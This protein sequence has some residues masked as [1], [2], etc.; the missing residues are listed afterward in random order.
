MSALTVLTVL[1]TQI[2]TVNMTTQSRKKDVCMYVFMYL[3]MYGGRN[4]FRKSMKQRADPS[5][6][7]KHRKRITYFIVRLKGR[8]NCE[9]LIKH[10]KSKDKE[11]TKYDRCSPH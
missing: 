10:L 3:C 9:G 8:N 6:Q 4:K 7:L 1:I 5:G 11:E 2:R